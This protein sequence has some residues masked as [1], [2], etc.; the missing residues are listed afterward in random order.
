MATKI[1]LLGQKFGKLTVIAP[2][3]S[4]KNGNAMWKCRCD[5][6]KE[7]F[8]K[9]VRLRGGY[10]QSCGCLRIENS[11]KSNAKRALNL[12]NQRFGSLIAIAPTNQRSNK[13]VV[14]KC[15]C[16]CG[17]ITF[18]TSHDLRT[19]NTKSCGC[20]RSKSFGEIKI[21]QLLKSYNIIYEKEKSFNNC[22]YNNN[23]LARFD[24]YL[25]KYNTLIEYDGK[26]HNIQGTGNYDNPAKFK[27]TQEHDK[28][29]TQ[30][31]K[32]NGYN[33]IRIPHTHYNDLTLNDLLPTTSSFLV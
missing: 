2:A 25:P 22:R 21:E 28:F 14:W 26:Q 15:Q 32:Q 18:V 31:A 5:C 23:Y 8:A 33:I 10:V 20:Q 19:G 4:D 3:P 13:C 24:F 27:L 11:N 7:I 16:D 30:W 12:T 9:G 1:N 17:K 6:G 29:K